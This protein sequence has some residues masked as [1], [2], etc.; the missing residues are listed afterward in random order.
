MDKT[1]FCVLDACALWFRMFFFATQDN[2]YIGM[3]NPSMKTSNRFGMEITNVGTTLKNLKFSQ[4]LV[5]KP[6]LVCIYILY[7]NKL[8]DSAMTAQVEKEPGA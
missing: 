2:A 7:F 3:T 4:K 1:I 5:V 8:F 6:G